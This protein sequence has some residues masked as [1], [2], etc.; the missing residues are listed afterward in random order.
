[1]K[2]NRPQV[3]PFWNMKAN[4]ARTPRGY[5][6]LLRA[7]R[8]ILRRCGGR[9]PVISLIECGGNWRVVERIARRRGYRIIT[10]TGDEGSSSALLVRT[11]VTLIDS[12]VIRVRD[13]WVGPKGKTHHGRA[14]PWATYK[15]GGR[16]RTTVVVHMPWNPRLNDD[17]WNACQRA[18]VDFA[19]K[20]FGFLEYLGDWNWSSRSTATGS[21]HGIAAKIGGRI[22]HTGDRLMFAIVRQARTGELDRILHV[23]GDAKTR[24]GSDHPYAV[25]RD[26]A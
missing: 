26:V 18:L 4:R 9:P 25:L 22:V 19:D 11:D 6:Q 5:V 17:A 3:R 24:E 10:G 21:P 8:R 2:P 7:M 20:R 12:G 1:M 14:F 23:A 15:L 16:V 13:K